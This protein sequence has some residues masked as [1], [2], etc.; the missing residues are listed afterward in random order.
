MVHRILTSRNKRLRAVYR[1][2]SN[3]DNRDYI[4]FHQSQSYD[5]QSTKMAL[6]LRGLSRKQT[7]VVHSAYVLHRSAVIYL[8]SSNDK[9]GLLKTPWD[10][11][12]SP[13]MRGQR[14]CFV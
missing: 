2:E 11:C 5:N 3:R 4:G 14:K 12:N 8:V 1:P 10:Q 7:E 6:G 13:V 9:H